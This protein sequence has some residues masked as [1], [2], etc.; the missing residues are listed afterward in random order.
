VKRRKTKTADR[1]IGITILAI[2]QL[3][4]ALMTLGLAVLSI[5]AALA[6]G[7]LGMFLLLFAAISLIIG[8]IGLILFYGLW[9][10]KGWAWIWTLIINILNIIFAL[11]PTIAL[12]SLVL[13]VIIVIYLLIPSTRA[14]FNKCEKSHMGGGTHEVESCTGTLA[15]YERSRAL[16]RC[17]PHL[18]ETTREIIAASKTVVNSMTVP[19]S[20]ACR[21]S[22]SRYEGSQ[23]QVR[24]WT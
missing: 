5:M 22:T 19:K 14:A 9:N 13:P 4:G 2:L 16:G 8:I 12:L 23:A 10:L 21:R 11:Y 3:L 6:L 17:R 15:R 18:S 1:P 7:P 24:Q 20:M